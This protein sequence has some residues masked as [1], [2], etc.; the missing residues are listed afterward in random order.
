MS[1]GVTSEE[2]PRRPALHSGMHPDEFRRW[3]YLKAELTGFARQLGLATSGSKCVVTARIDSALAGDDAPRDDIR[4]E[5]R[6]GPQLRRPV[7]RASVIPAG[8]RCSQV[9]REFFREEVGATFRF[10]AS[11][12]EF[13]AN[14][15]GRTLGEAVD[16]WWTTR[17]RGGAPIGPQFELNRF[18]RQWWRANLGGTRDE[19]RAAWVTYRNEPD[20]ARGRA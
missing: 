17:G 2:V 13:V 8:Q 16:H 19:L 5:G 9:L 3:Y 10:D 20:D 1:A 18:T 7:S 11:M 4:R 14:G 6:G 12:R 15:T